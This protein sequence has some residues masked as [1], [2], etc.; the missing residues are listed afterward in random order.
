MKV[1]DSEMEDGRPMKRMAI[2]PRYVDKHHFEECVGETINRCQELID[3]YVTAHPDMFNNQTSLMMDIRKIREVTDASYY[4]VVIR[5]NLEGTQSY[6]IFDDGVIYYPW[7]WTV[8]GTDQS[9][10]PWDCEMN[11]VYMTP[12]ECCAMIQDDVGLADDKGEYLACFV[13]EPV[14]GPSNPERDDRA[15]VVTNKGGTVVRPPVAH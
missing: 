13:E 9:I 8:G 7:P 14:G 12:A 2:I 10:G 6:G 5:T 15:I 3:A 1:M 4:K 11:G